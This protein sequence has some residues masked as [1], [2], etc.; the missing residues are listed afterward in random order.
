M[1]AID[2]VIEHRCQYA[3]ELLSRYTP[4]A[5]A[6]LFGAW[7]EGGA[8]EG[9]DIDL[10][11]FLEDLESWDLATR[12]HTAALVQEKA[13]DDIALHFLSVR[14]LRQP[15]SASLAAYVLIHGV[16]ITP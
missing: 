15:E 1:A 5:A 8:D 14:S 16:A 3:V 13:G 9:R 10:A 6:Y 4:V 12:A 2:A 7:V 11:V